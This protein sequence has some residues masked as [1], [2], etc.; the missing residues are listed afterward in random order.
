MRE[1]ARELAAG[2]VQGGYL[3]RK[4]EG[5]LTGEWIVFA[6]QGGTNYYLTLSRHGEDEAIWH[7]TKACA[8]EFPEL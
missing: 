5:K 7:R 8:A 3:G 1:A 4:D 2:F 6:V